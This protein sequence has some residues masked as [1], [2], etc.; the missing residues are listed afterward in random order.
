MV[1]RYEDLVGPPAESVVHEM[2][3]FAGLRNRMPIKHALECASINAT[4]RKHVASA[5]Q[6]LSVMGRNFS[7][8]LWATL[9]QVA[10]P[11]G[12]DFTFHERGEGA[13]AGGARVVHTHTPHMP[14]LT[15][16]Y[17]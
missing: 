12:Y 15:H 8:A 13:A 1:F 5:E 17:V 10:S 2:L 9:K 14:H 4:H 7:V 6:V 11:L 3:R 16:V